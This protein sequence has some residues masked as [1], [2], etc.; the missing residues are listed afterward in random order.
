MES[1]GEEKINLKKIEEQNILTDEEVI[2]SLDMKLYKERIENLIGKQY[3]YLFFVYFE[4]FYHSKIKNKISLTLTEHLDKDNNK[5]ITLWM[6][7]YKS[8]KFYSRENLPILIT[9]YFKLKAEQELKFVFNESKK[10]TSMPYKFIDI[11]LKKMKKANQ[12]KLI[13]LKAINPNLD[14]FN[15]HKKQSIFIRSFLPKKTILRPKLS[16]LR[17]Q[18]D[19]FNQEEEH[20]DLSNRE[21]EIKNKK[22]M[23]LQIIKQVHKLKIDSIKEVEKANILQNKQKKKYGGIKSRF[24]DAYNEQ[25][26]FFKIIKSKSS[27]KINNNNFYNNK[28]TDFERANLSTK[29]FNNSKVSSRTLLYLNTKENYASRKNFKLNSFF[30]EEKKNIK[31]YSN[32]P[33][34]FKKNIKKNKIKFNHITNKGFT[35]KNLQA[36]NYFRIDSKNEI[37][38]KID[39]RVLLTSN[40]INKNPKFKTNKFKLKEYSKHKNFNSTKNFIGNKRM[41]KNNLNFKKMDTNNLIEKLDKK[42][43]KEILENLRLQKK[44]N[45]EYNN[46]IYNIF[47]RTEI[48]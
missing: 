21:Q 28:L 45:G 2:N 11:Y 15:I 36:L 32:R 23:R 25:E 30:P 35:P 39:H 26:K 27:R 47:K 1:D 19:M 40:N 4:N 42:R 6:R 7:V 9:K 24:L 33:N 31:N 43:N 13:E 12:K 16:L 8:I 37:P 17:N 22:E 38:K 20:S 10:Y 41:N 3:S 44:E 48:L 5:N 46:I 34:S 29:K 18:L 14:I